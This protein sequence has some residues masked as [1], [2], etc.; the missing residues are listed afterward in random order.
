V[1]TPTVL[2]LAIALLALSGVFWVI[3]RRRPALPQQRRRADDT[4]V[5]LAYWFSRR[6]SRAR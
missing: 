3:E 2:S 6:W 5:D 1:R 4:R